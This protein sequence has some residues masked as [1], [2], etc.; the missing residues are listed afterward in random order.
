VKIA[1]LHYTC[2]PVVGGVEIIMAEHARLFAGHGH[3]VTVYC[4]RGAS[5]DLRIRV[6]LLPDA[7]DAA[8]LSRALEPELAGQDV[9]IMHNVATM[10][11]H[12]AL[13]EAL[14]DL[15]EKLTGVRFI[16]WV[17]DLAACNPDYQLP[18]LDAPPWSLIARAHPRY[19]Y[20]AV[21][22]LRR[23]QFEKLTGVACRVAPN[24][25]DPGRLLGLTAPV[26]EFARVHS[27]LER[28][29]VLFHPARLLRRKNVELGLRVAAA[30]K[31][32][33]KNCAYLV[34]AA[35][36]PHQ[37]ASRAYEKELHALRLELG[38]EDDAL[39]VQEELPIDELD[40]ASLYALSDA[41]FFPSR[42]EGFGLPVLEAALHRLPI[43]CA[44]IEPLDSLLTDGVSFFPLDAEPAQIA[45][46]IATRL[47]SLDAW[48]AR[49]QA[50]RQYAW[51]AVYRNHIAPLLTP[52][53]IPAL[54]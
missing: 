43:F 3:E 24:G 10:P 23:R 54:L 28:D 6:E 46:E 29:I 34:T 52:R 44:A 5:D 20:V 8:E 53:E 2:T 38:M 30:L 35:P 37:A 42:Q 4:D 51:P 13:T 1:L 11:F 17:H 12:L 21:S 40:L 36:D 9:V 18:P 47:G 14:W 16:A 22:D 31:A 27:L 50:R 33:G 48:R 15:A 41:L 32:A 7:K 39:F 49:N 25:L 19:S 26:A 45:L